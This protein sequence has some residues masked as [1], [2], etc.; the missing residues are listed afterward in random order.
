MKQKMH[1]KKE[2]LLCLL[3]FL[4]LLLF[5]FLCLAFRQHRFNVKKDEDQ[6]QRLLV[7]TQYSVFTGC[8]YGQKNLY[9][10][11][12]AYIDETDP[13]QYDTSALRNFVNGATVPN[14]RFR[15]LQ[16]VQLHPELQ[17]DGKLL[18]ERFYSLDNALSEALPFISYDD[19][20]Q[21]KQPYSQLPS[22]LHDDSREIDSLSEIVLSGVTPEETQAVITEINKVLDT[23]EE[24]L[25]RYER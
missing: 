18:M 13:Q 21:L 4:N 7:Y 19:L 1:D 9:E 2:R 8:V 12:V 14:H 6:Y 17:D 5:L 24:I 11:Y 23:V 10:I 20:Q 25:S 16:A 3:I 15:F 22:L